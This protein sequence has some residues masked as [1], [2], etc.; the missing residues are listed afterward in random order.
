[1]LTK[2]LLLAIPIWVFAPAAAIAEDTETHRPVP[3]DTGAVRA[4]ASLLSVA[5]LSSADSLHGAEASMA[6]SLLEAELSFC[7]LAEEHGIRAAF[8]AVLDTE[9]I[10]FRPDPVNARNWY[11]ARD[12]IAGILSWQPALVEASGDLGF[13]TGPWQFRR[14]SPGEDP[15]AFGDYVSVWSWVGP[16]PDGWRL[17]LDLGVGHAAPPLS[18]GGT[19]PLLMGGRI[20]DQ[21]LQDTALG[22]SAAALGRGAARSALL[23]ADRSF[24]AELATRDAAAVFAEHT[25]PGSRLLREGHLPAFGPAAIRLLLADSTRLV[26]WT[27]RQAGISDSLDLGYTWGDVRVVRTHAADTLSVHYL[28]TWR[29]EPSV[30]DWKLVLECVPEAP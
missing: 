30:G 4:E 11:V 29:I 2:V 17:L 6:S 26:A 3:A 9:G 21:A 13:T 27:P 16:H 19:S 24:C 1:M 8:L 15:V 22:R 14:G 10:V 28:R 23:D 7:R 18:P 20:R 12:S 25:T 5:G